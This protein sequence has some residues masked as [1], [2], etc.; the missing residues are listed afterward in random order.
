MNE[1]VTLNTGARMPRIGLGTWQSPLS[2]V[3]SAVKAAIDAGY[4]HIDT[5]Y[6]YGNEAAIG[7]ALQEVF[8][9]GK[10]RREDLFITTKLW[11]TFHRPEHVRECLEYSLRQLQLGYVDLY[12]VHNTVAW[13]Y[14][15]P[16]S[17]GRAEDDPVPFQQTWH[18]MEELV[19]LGLAKAIGVSNAC[20][21]M[22]WD[23]LAYARI[24]PAMNQIELHPFCPQPELIQYCLRKGIQVTAYSPLGSHG[25]RA[26]A[27]DATQ[28]VLLED[29]VVRAIAAKHHQTPAQVCL[30]W[31]YQR[32]GGRL[33]V[34]PKS[35]RPDHIRDN[36]G[37]CGWA[38]DE[39]DMRQLDSRPFYRFFDKIEMYGVPLFH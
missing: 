35:T 21:A 19:D 31:A 2:E 11:N 24:P 28:N 26:A 12:L 39:A 30:R 34:I 9:E 25:T 27:G 37:M 18:A 33:C 1:F 13:K 7:E 3:K 15:P 8:A 23:I 16:P 29:P 36:L 10:I 14:Q 17:L 22:L 6:A 20:G 32:E 4:R 5:A 38:L